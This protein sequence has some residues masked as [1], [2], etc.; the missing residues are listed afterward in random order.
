MPAPPGGMPYPAGVHGPPRARLRMP[1]LPAVLRTAVLG[2][3]VAALAP[4]PQ[5]AR[6]QGHP[7]PAPPPPFH[8]RLEAADAVAVV[9]VL[10]VEPGRLH[11]E[12]LATLRGAPPARFAVKRAPSR[13]PALEAGDRAVMLMQG[14]RPP[15]VLA[16]PDRD[17]IRLA[18]DEAAQRWQAALAA[19]VAAGDDPEARLRSYVAWIDEG[20]ATLAEAGLVGALAVIAAS[21]ERSEALSVERARAA[22]DP[23]RTPEARRLSAL[24]AGTTG[25]GA[26]VLVEGSARGEGASPAVVLAAL[27]AGARFG[28][29][30]LG[31]AFRRAASH[32]DAEVRLAALQAARVVEPHAPDG[33]REVVAG[34]AEEDPEE[35]VRRQAERVAVMLET[36]P[37]RGIGPH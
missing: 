5:A 6:A 14:A 32:P 15:Y 34:L 30:G 7:L 8:G 4:A 29:P 16:A 18:D 10:E 20:P 28:S 25:A 27:S 35:G 31:A 23:A 36:G 21:P 9:R 26:A 33:V 22:T 1:R 24:L 11:V 12:R 3:A 37:L 19:L 13:P 17:A 2:L